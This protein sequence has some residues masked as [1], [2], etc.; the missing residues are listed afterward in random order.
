MP[1]A[2]SNQLEH[3][4]YASV[5]S[6]G[7]LRSLGSFRTAVFYICRSLFVFDLDARALHPDRKS[8]Y[9]ADVYSGA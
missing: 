6:V 8:T 3:H 9:S 7:V 4:L 2:P 5:N 1:I